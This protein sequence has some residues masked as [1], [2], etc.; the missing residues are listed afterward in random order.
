MA[1]A[2]C[3]SVIMVLFWDGSLQLVVT[4]GRLA[5]AVGT[6]AEGGTGRRVGAR[7]GISCLCTDRWVVNPC[8]LLIRGGVTM[9]LTGKIALITGATSGI[10]FHTASALACQGA[11]V[12]ITGRDVSR[13]QDA[14][15]QICVMAGQ[16]GVHFIKADAATVGGN[17][18]LAQRLLAQ[19]DRLHILVNNVGGTYND[20]WPT[21]DGYEATL[22]MNFVGPFA[23]TQ[24]LL[25][26]LQRSA[27]AR[28]V[29]VTSAAI[30]MWKGELFADIHSEQ[31]YL[32]SQAY[33]RA[34]LFNILWTFALARRLEG[35]GVVANAADPGTAWT[36]MTAGIEQRSLPPW[37]SLIWPLFRWLQRRGSAENAARSS[38]FL[39]SA[40]EAASITGT[41]IGSKVRP[42]RPPAAALDRA[43]QEKTWELAATL[44]SNAPT[45]IG[46]ERVMAVGTAAATP[47]AVT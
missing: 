17:Q 13:G 18:Q 4:K 40:P 2:V 45:A 38:I 1:S 36:S 41:Y 33:A 47:V 3:S 34:K 26:L 31:S 23:L 24:A 32:G 20:R 37:V 10:G 5:Y 28:I 46:T 15:R 16:S 22:A 8:R 25:P 9:P 35:S 39:A 29:N 11:T 14:E 42:A 19:S 6:L 30:G 43:N 12:Y 21:D 7:C 27:P 44:V